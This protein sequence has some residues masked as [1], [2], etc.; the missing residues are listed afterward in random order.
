[1]ADTDSSMTSET[2][3]SSHQGSRSVHPVAPLYE[4]FLDVFPNQI[5]LPNSYPLAVLMPIFE[6][7]KTRIEMEENGTGFGVPE[8]ASAF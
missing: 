5:L 6:A 2:E 7:I 1:M 4:N 8:T 3:L